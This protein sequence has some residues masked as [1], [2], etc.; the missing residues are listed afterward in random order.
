[1]YPLAATLRQTL[2]SEACR[3][4]HLLVS[5]CR[6]G[7]QGGTWGGKKER[8]RRGV[9]H[10][11]GGRTQGKSNSKEENESLICVLVWSTMVHFVWK[12][13]GRQDVKWDGIG[14]ERTGGEE[15]YQEDR[16]GQS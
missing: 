9:D 4:D 2:T 11:Q 1:M 3:R 13:L 15:E 6:K 7:E 16:I 8:R 5:I 10:G 12:G 14:W